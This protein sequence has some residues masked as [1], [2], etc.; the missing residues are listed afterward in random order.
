ML[1]VRAI[2]GSLLS[3]KQEKGSRGCNKELP[4]GVKSVD[5]AESGGD[6]PTTARAN[7]KAA[8]APFITHGMV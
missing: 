1:S 8:G 7:T 5:D 6:S 4:L 2:K 3:T